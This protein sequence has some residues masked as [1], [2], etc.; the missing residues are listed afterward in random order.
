MTFTAKLSTFPTF[1][2]L[3]LPTVNRKKEISDLFFFFF[4]KSSLNP[5]DVFV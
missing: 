1:V 4:L 5:D 2:Q 3:L